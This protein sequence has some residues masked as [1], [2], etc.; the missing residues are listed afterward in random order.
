M[1]TCAEEE[2]EEE[3]LCKPSLCISLPPEG[4]AIISPVSGSSTIAPIPPPDS[5]PDE[6]ELWKG[7][8]AIPDL[9]PNLLRLDTVLINP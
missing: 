6:S 3:E 2:E 9:D 1:P 8:R 7:L 5:P 4:A